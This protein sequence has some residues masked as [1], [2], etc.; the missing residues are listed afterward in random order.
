MELFLSTNVLVTVGIVY[1]LPDYRNILQEFIWQVP[2]TIP[3]LRRVHKFLNFW[4]SNIDAVIQKVELGI[5]DRYGEPQW[6]AIDWVGK[7]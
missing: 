1:Y 6:R 4:K 7:V 2:D 5:P 3:E